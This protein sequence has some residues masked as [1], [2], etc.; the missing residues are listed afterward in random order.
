MDDHAYMDG[1]VDDEDT[2][3][4]TYDSRKYHHRRMVSRDEEEDTTLPERDDSV[5]DL[6]IDN[7]TLTLP[8]RY[9]TSRSNMGGEDHFLI[10]H[11][12]NVFRRWGAG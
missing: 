12:H 11:V 9:Q 7:E 4:R 3:D 2:L 6:T 1:T 10:S 8:T 5:N